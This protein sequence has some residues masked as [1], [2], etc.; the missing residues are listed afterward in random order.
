LLEAN[1]VSAHYNVIMIRYY[2]ISK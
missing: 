2:H 1:S